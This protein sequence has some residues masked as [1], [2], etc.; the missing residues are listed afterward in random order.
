MKNLLYI[1]FFIPLCLACKKEP[2]GDPIP[3]LHF[4]DFVDASGKNLFESGKIDTSEFHYISGDF[5]DTWEDLMAGKEFSITSFFNITPDRTTVSNEYTETIDSLRN[6][7][8][9]LLESDQGTLER[10]RV[11][12][13]NGIQHTFRYSL[14]DGF[15]QDGKKLQSSTE[16]LTDL[17]LAYLHHVVLEEY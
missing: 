11:I 15:Y 5:I 16:L 1:L 12:S 17:H 6:N 8:N 2:I 10:E 3:Q 9:I 14:K 4:I 13:I 7:N